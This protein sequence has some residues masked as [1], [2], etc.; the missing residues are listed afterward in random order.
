MGE[1]SDRIQMTLLAPTIASRQPLALIPR[2]TTHP[3]RYVL[4][5]KVGFAQHLAM[6]W[7]PMALLATSPSSWILAMS[8]SSD[9]K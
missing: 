2:D 3:F 8:A 6:L 1:A 7:S 5:R 4:G 9:G